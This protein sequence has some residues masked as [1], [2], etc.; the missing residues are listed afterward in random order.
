MRLTFE[1]DRTADWECTTITSPQTCTEPE[2]SHIVQGPAEIYYGSYSIWALTQYLSAWYTALASP[3]A[4]P[5]IEAQLQ[6]DNDGA[7]S[8]KALLSLLVQN[9]ASNTRLAT[10]LSVVVTEG[11]IDIADQIQPTLKT[12]QGLLGDLLAGTLNEITSDWAGGDF[13]FL[14]TS[15]GLLNNTED[16]VEYLMSRLARR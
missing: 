7:I 13:M 5:A 6:N 1:G 12:A 9:Y 14:G 16:T 8:T 4:M 3:S 2:P 10:S 15:G 11:P